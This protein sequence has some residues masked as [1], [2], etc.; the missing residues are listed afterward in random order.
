MK[1]NKLLTVA[2]V[3]CFVA[4]PVLVLAAQ[5]SA[6][7][8]QH[9]EKQL[10]AMQAQVAQLQKQ[11]Q[12][13][14][15]VSKKRKAKV[16]AN[17]RT[18]SPLQSSA[19]AQ[20][21]QLLPKG[22]VVI[23]P[24][25]GQ[26]TFYSGGQ[27]IVNAPSVNEDAKLLYRRFLNEQEY[28]KAGMS[29]S[30]KPRLVLSGQVEGQASYAQPY[31]GRYSSD[32]DL[33]GAELDALAEILPWVN[34][35]MAMTYDNNPTTQTAGM[36][37]NNRRISNSRFYLDKGF[38]T[39]GNFKKSGFYGSVGQLVVPFGRYSSSMIASPLTSALGK[40][41]ARAVTF[42]FIADPQAHLITPYG[43]L[44]IFKGDTKYGSHT[45]AVKNYGADIGS[46]FGG[47][48][49]NG[50][51]GVSYLNNIADSNGMQDNARGAG[52][53]GF[54]RTS[55][56]PSSETIV[57][58]V[59]GADLHGNVAYGPFSLLGE[60]VTAMQQFART[61][62]TYDGHGARPNA[63]NG[64]AAYSFRVFSMPSS[65]AI[66]YGFS[67]QAL[68][69]GIPHQRY[70]ASWALTIMRNTVFTLEGRHDINYG[71]NKTATGNSGGG[72]TAS[73]ITANQL[74][75]TNNAV[76]ARIAVYF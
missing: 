68:A 54:E 73:A 62:L 53:M 17:R 25:T 50:G 24:F 11:Q 35:F 55:G 18:T 23:A 21:Y 38:I 42:N 65:F 19:P 31:S 40:T 22:S 44:F 30:T 20:P 3:I 61:D 64:E 12:V 75:K 71:K 52:F 16:V 37:G 9:M 67:R 48:Q 36:I 46:W 7:K 2:S 51:L 28:L 45:N 63:L 13:R 6:I 47:Q 58:R 10:A 76:A 49:F 39:I 8:L 72:M 1:I 14:T 56:A 5:P 29:K 41:K 70:I 59:G 33:T 74:G 32:I 4:T 27:L 34:G 57:H 43:H 60:Y 26:P 66:G 69:L 15:V